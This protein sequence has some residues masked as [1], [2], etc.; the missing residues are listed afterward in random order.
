VK[1][2]AVIGLSLFKFIVD[3]YP[4]KS[5]AARDLIY[6]CLEGRPVELEGPPWFEGPVDPNPGEW[7]AVSCTTMV[8]AE[9]AEEFRSMAKGAGMTLSKLARSC[10]RI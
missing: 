8:P 3:Q 6:R 5:A 1:T 7:R 9:I 4:S 2:Y 10:I